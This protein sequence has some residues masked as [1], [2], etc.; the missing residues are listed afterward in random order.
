MICFR[1]YGFG[2]RA[3]V[4]EFISTMR[5]GNNA[6]KKNRQLCLLNFS[7]FING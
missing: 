6:V 1:G 3:Q 2:R 7:T 4:S 5:A